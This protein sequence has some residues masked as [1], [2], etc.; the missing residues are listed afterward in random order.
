MRLI[1]ETRVQAAI[2]WKNSAYN[3]RRYA[4]GEQQSLANHL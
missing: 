4:F 2:G 1:G 3:F